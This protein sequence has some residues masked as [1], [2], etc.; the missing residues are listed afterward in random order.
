M[1]LEETLRLIGAN[2]Q[3]IRD[4][5]NNRVSGLVQAILREGDDDDLG[6]FTDKFFAELEGSDGTGS[7]D[8]E[9]HGEADGTSGPVGASEV[10][11][12]AARESGSGIEVGEE[13]VG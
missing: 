12:G 8:T 2:N 7:G 6:D 11:G 1:S 4:A 5:A 13:A 9:P 3:A 10:G